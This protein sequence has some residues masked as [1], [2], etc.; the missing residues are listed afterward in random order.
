VYGV[1]PY[2]A[3]NDRVKFTGDNIYSGAMADI[4]PR[5]Y[6]IDTQWIGTHLPWRSN[7]SWAPN[8]VGSK[9]ISSTEM[10]WKWK[11]YQYCKW[12]NPNGEWI[13]WY[14]WIPI[15]PTIFTRYFDGSP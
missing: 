14:D 12:Q 4:W 5:Y 3:F 13:Y 11:D 6:Q 10:V 8:Q 2:N 15:S 1:E 9:A 7:V